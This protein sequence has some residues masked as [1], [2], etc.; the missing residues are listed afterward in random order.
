MNI[1][2]V[3]DEKYGPQAAF[4]T[5]KVAERAAA[6]GY[7]TMSGYGVYVHEMEVE[8]VVPEVAL[9]YAKKQGR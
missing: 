8:T 3:V 2:L 6:T 7:Y 9:N 5:E 1:Y 4:K